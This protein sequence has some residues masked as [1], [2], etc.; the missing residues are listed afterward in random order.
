VVGRRPLNDEE[1]DGYLESDQDFVE[2]QHGRVRVVV[3]GEPGR[4]RCVPCGETEVTKE[5]THYR[6]LLARRKKL[7]VEIEEARHMA[8]KGAI[9]TCVAL[10]EEFGLT[11][12]DL[13]FVKA[14]QIP[15][16]KV[17]AGDKTFAVKKPKSVKPPKYVDPASGKT[18][19]GYGHQPGWIVGNRDE[20]LIKTDP[21]K[22]V[23][24]NN[25]HEL[26]EA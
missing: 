19:S 16:N 18:W 1:P 15:P 7:D 25:R 11:T 6:E 5:T 17:K 9:E 26:Q 23:T 20:Y 3:S 22:R 12:V 10:I 24:Q 8:A 13:G 14:R 2:Q 4:Y 21:K